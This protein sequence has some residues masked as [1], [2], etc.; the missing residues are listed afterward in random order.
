MHWG[1]RQAPK[2]SRPARSPAGSRLG[3]R[4]IWPS[5]YRDSNATAAGAFTRNEFAAPPVKLDQ[6][7]L[8][9]NQTRIRAVIAN[10]GNANACT[11]ERGERDA[12]GMQRACAE[13]LSL[14]PDQVLVLSTGVIGVPLPMQRVTEGIRALPAKLAKQGGMDA[15]RAIM[16]TDTAP[17]H[18]SLRAS[19]ADRAFHLGGTAKGSGM[20]HPNMATMLAVVTTDAQVP[21]AF[22]QTALQHAVSV[23][24]NA[25]SVD[26]DTSTNDTVLLLA[27]AP[28]QWPST[29]LRQGSASRT[30]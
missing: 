14:D 20:I 15:A 8:A 1:R 26:G 16:T 4:W 29:P 25:I 27:N 17:K 30:R 9:A 6:A 13:M 11:G 18:L 5:S 10:A 7:T 23:S 21:A 19:L 12:A 2:V 3:A 24:F 28:A 22:L